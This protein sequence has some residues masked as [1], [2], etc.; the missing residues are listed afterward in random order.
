MSFDFAVTD[1]S[2]NVAES[3]EADEADVS[4]DYEANETADLYLSSG[5]YKSVEGAILEGLGKE[6]L[7]IQSDDTLQDA[8]RLL[9]KYEDAHP[10]QKLHMVAALF[11]STVGKMQRDNNDHGIGLKNG[12]APEEHFESSVSYALHFSDLPT[13][14]FDDLDGGERENLE[15][16][17]VNPSE[18]GFDPSHKGP[19]LLSIDGERLPIAV[20]DG[21]EV[22]EALEL[23]QKVPDEPSSYGE[24]GLQESSDPSVFSNTEESDNPSSGTSTSN[25]SNNNSSNKATFNGSILA[26]VPEH[27]GEF[28]CEEIKNQVSD[29][30]SQRTLMRILS[31]EQQGQNRSVTKRIEQRKRAV[32]GSEDEDEVEADDDDDEESIDLTES[33]MTL[34]STL[35]DTGKAE[36]LPDAAQQIRSL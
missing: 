23:L 6:P 16:M 31:A 15:E 28:T 5:D 27:V 34:A 30:T 24:D 18:L 32:E 19:K 11:K 7:K 35:I 2:S 20:E 14:T 13:I 3:T 36:D 26:E 25:S 1:D 12:K 4:P 29:I 17:G 21:S 8:G 22:I 33:E 10:Q 9:T